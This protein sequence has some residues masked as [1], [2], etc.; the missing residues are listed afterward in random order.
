MPAVLRDQL[1]SWINALTE[2]N[3]TDLSMMHCPGA[4]PDRDRPASQ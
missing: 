3:R 4:Y 1:Q 2:L